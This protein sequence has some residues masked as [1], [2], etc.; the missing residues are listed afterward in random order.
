MRPSSS[1]RRL[2]R[3]TL[4]A[5]ALGLAAAELAAGCILFSSF[6]GLTGG[7]DDAGTPDNLDSACGQVIVALCKS[8]PR[9][10]S[11]WEQV[12]DGDPA[13]FCA[14]PRATFEPEKGEFRT[15]PKPTWLAEAAPRAV[16]HAAWSDKALHIHVRVDKATAI[17]PN[18]VGEL[19]NGDALEIFAGN[20]EVPT[21]SFDAD[22]VLH[23]ILAPPPSEGAPGALSTS[24]VWSGPW[25]TRRDDEGYDA[26]LEIPWSSLGGEPPAAGRAILWN[27]GLDVAGPA[28]ER[29]QSFVRYELPDGGTAWCHEDNLPK[30]SIDDRSFCSPELA[31]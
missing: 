10:P 21:G 13:E 15:C 3:I 4:S 23:L 16:L 9:V 27:V 17:T 12:V 29:Y 20:V 7:P 6:D 31:P 14:I 5:F 18:E 2:A 24:K 22:H 25:I 8:I 30:P 11:G 1:P 19:Y 26:E 28:G